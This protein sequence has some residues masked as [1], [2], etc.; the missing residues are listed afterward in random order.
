MNPEA[1]KTLRKNKK[2][3]QKELGKILNTSTQYYQKY[4]KGIYTLPTEHVI[5]L[6]LF[7]NVTADYILGLPKG[8]KWPREK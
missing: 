8:L 1:L 5:T 6:S 2:L 4:E 3:T 7:Y